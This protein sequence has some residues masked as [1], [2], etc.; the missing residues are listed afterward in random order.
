ML[1]LLGRSAGRKQTVRQLY[2]TTVARA[3]EPVFFTKL[4]VPDTIDGRF[5]LL[6]LHAWMVLDR[7]REAKLPDLSQAFIDTVFIGFDEGLRDLGAGD[8]GMGRRMKKLADA[9]YGR[10]S[11]YEGSESIQ[12]MSE[13]LLRNLYRGA[14]DVQ[15]AAIVARY[16][17]SARAH[18]AQSD[19]AAGELDFGPLP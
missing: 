9:F 16:V 3:R 12:T 11:S 18:V 13:S 5:D 14:G 4:G 2:A 1:H 17:D 15:S 8:M 19:I 7:L 6:A 10:M